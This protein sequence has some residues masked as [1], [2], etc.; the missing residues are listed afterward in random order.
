MTVQQLLRVAWLGSKSVCIWAAVQPFAATCGASANAS[1]RT[2]EVTISGSVWPLFQ[3]LTR[4]TYNFWAR[5]QRSMLEWRGSWSKFSKHLEV[6]WCIEKTSSSEKASQVMR[7][8][9]VVICNLRRS[10]KNSKQVWD[11]STATGLLMRRRR[12]CLSPMPNTLS[13]FD[14]AGAT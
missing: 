11:A 5:H 2:K 7:L 13:S 14:V 1:A 6:S 12:S 10:E 4:T 8:M 9:H 3:N